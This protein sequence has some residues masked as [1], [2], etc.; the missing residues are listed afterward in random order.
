MF[1]LHVIKCLMDNYFHD[2]YSLRFIAFVIVV[3]CTGG[4]FVLR[5]CDYLAFSSAIGSWGEDIDCLYIFAC[6]MSEVTTF[7]TLPLSIQFLI[8]LSSMF[9][10]YIFIR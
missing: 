8:N 9:R 7:N 4:T 5:V 3:Q 1:V 10:K 6:T 2:V